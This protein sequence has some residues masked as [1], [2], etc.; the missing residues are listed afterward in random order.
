MAMA[1]SPAPDAKHS[2]SQNAATAGQFDELVHL[3]TYH[4]HKTAPFV[5]LP[6]RTRRPGA[7]QEFPGGTLFPLGTRPFGRPL[8]QRYCMALAA[9]F[10]K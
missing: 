4:Q 9:L 3:L 7:L 8:C 5:L 6:L 10:K 1:Q 2:Y